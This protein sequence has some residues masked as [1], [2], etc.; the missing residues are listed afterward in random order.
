[1][2]KFY[3]DQIFDHLIMAIKT[4]FPAHKTKI[5]LGFMEFCFIY[6]VSKWLVIVP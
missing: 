3:A 6:K 5:I 2:V 1:M 4:A